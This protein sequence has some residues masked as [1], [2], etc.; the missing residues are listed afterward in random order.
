MTHLFCNALHPVNEVH[1]RNPPE[2]LQRSHYVNEF[3]ELNFPYAALG[4][5]FYV[6]MI[7]RSTKH[8]LFSK[9]RCFIHV[10]GNVR[11]MSLSIRPLFLFH[12]EHSLI[13]DVAATRHRSFELLYHA[14]PPRHIN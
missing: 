10:C 13:K 3:A 2:S 6:R 11:E 8:T 14:Y 12:P 7:I 1:L 5:M 9:C 4:R